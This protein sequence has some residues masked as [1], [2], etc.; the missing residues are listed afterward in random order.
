MAVT[1]PL[2]SERHELVIEL[3][4]H[5]FPKA[6][7]FRLTT[8]YILRADSNAAEARDPA[9]VQSIVQECHELRRQHLDWRERYTAFSIEHS[10]CNSPRFKAREFLALSF[11]SQLLVT[12]FILALTPTAPGSRELAEEV[13]DMAEMILMLHEWARLCQDWQCDVLMARKLTCARA[14]IATKDWWARAIGGDVNCL[15]ERGTIGKALFVEWNERI[16]REWRSL[17]GEMTD[18]TSVF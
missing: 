10:A 4:T 18:C 2:G 6:R 9:I 8:D 11:S 14:A 15:T 5:V 17:P 1:K 16:G 12:Q 7:L 3:W 13:Q